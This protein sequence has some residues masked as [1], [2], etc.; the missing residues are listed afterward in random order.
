LQA[1]RRID[2]ALGHLEKLAQIL[3]NTNDECMRDSIAV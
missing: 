1:T 3:T 2:S